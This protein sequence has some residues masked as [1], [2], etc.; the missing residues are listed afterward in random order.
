MGLRTAKIHSNV[1]RVRITSEAAP[2]RRVMIGYNP[3]TG[4][5][6]SSAHPE[7]YFRGI[8]RIVPLAVTC[9]AYRIGR[10]PGKPSRNFSPPPR[11]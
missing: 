5:H 2:P 10:Y 3:A 8:S 7:R 1:N 11:W 9:L 4:K 6:A